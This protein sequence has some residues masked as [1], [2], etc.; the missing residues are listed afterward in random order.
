MK[1]LCR[2]LVLFFSN[3]QKLFLM[4]VKHYDQTVLII[5]VDKYMNVLKGSLLLTKA[6]FI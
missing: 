1:L 4:I 6:V 2:Q 5:I 3:L